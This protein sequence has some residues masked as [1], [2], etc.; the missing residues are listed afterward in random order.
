M[1]HAIQGSEV[2]AMAELAIDRFGADKD[3]IQHLA[4]WA[5]R[6]WLAIRD[7]FP[8]PRTEVELEATIQVGEH[9][10]HLTGHLD[11]LAIV[12]HEGRLVDFKT[13]R[14]ADA[15]DAGPQLRGYG[16]LTLANN[17]HCDRVYAAKVNVRE[18][19]QDASLYTREQLREWFAEQVPRWLAG[20]YNPGAHCQFCHRRL[21]C[22]A[23]D[24][25]LDKAIAIVA[26]GR[27]MPLERIGEAY[28]L[29]R[30]VR[31]AADEAWDALKLLVEDT[32]SLPTGDGRELRIVEQQ[33][34]VISPVWGLPVL[35]ELIGEE[36]TLECLAVRKGDVE[37]AVKANAANGQKGKAIAE[38]FRRLEAVGALGVKVVRKLEA[39]RV[40]EPQLT[41]E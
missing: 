6:A 41:E 9:T 12:A 1:E 10:L 29:I 8:H 32:G 14:L 13:G 2:S 35:N 40:G 3:E 18:Q 22:T 36:R 20:E 4:A 11:V 38:L 7:K 21:D 37:D 16:A 26:L 15:T 17:P 25:Y 27:E 39:K 19:T 23:R 34:K 30:T 28:D 24:R 31:K 5:W 33:Q